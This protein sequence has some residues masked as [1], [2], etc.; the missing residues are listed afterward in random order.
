MDD[1]VVVGVQR[2]SSS[3]VEVWRGTN[4]LGSHELTGSDITMTVEGRR[5]YATLRDSAEYD[6]VLYVLEVD[7][8]GGI[9]ELSSLVMG[10]YHGDV[11]ANGD[12]LYVANTE[13]LA[14]DIR[15]PANPAIVGSGGDLPSSVTVEMGDGIV[16]ASTGG[17]RGYV[18][19]WDVSEPHTP[20]Q[21][22]EAEIPGASSDMLYKDGWLYVALGYHGVA[23]FDASDP[24]A[25][26]EIHRHRTVDHA[27]GLDVV[28]G[29]LYV[30]DTF[31]LLQ[32][33]RLRCGR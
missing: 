9:N 12:T 17:S 8:A 5:I 4:K 25:L 1:L 23:I 28:D 16:Y 26:T 10:D 21:I 11:A 7:R 2:L 15:D 3:A 31:G 6:G 22:A 24:T 30:A 19:A 14:V 27:W 29:R 18:G 33:G 32:T 20:M 13:L